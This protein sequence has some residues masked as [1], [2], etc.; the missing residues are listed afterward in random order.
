MLPGAPAHARTARHNPVDLTGSLMP[1]PLL[2]IILYIAKRRFIRQRTDGARP[3]SLSVAENNLRVFM[4]LTLI[5][6]GKVQ[7]N[8]RLLISLKTKERLKGNVE[9]FLS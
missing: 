7:V 3:V 6:P 2:I 5:F 1:A 8:I 9:P 4:G